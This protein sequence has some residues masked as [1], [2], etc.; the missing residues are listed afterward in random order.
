MTLRGS[1]AIPTK[2]VTGGGQY[3]QG[4]VFMGVL[5]VGKVCWTTNPIL[6]GG[7]VLLQQLNRYQE[8]NRGELMKDMQVSLRPV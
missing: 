3:R 6:Q 5:R 4:Q 1:G 7:R 2:V 8:H